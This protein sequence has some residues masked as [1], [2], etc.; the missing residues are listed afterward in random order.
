[1][2]PAVRNK[3]LK[4]LPDLI[5]LGPLAGMAFLVVLVYVSLRTG[6]GMPS[7][8]A[9][10]IFAAISAAGYLV[11]NRRSLTGMLSAKT[12]IMLAV[13]YVL[14]YLLFLSPLLIDGHAGVTGYDVAND[15]VMHA[16]I[17]ESLGDKGLS[18][19]GASKNSYNQIVEVLVIKYGYPVGYHGILGLVYKI[20]GGRAYEYFSAVVACVA[21]GLFFAAFFLLRLFG[22]R[23]IIAIPGALLA[24]TAYL[25][26]GYLMH[27]FAPQVVSTPFVYL[28]MIMLYIS[29]R[30]QPNLNLSILTGVAFAAAFT[31]YS[32]V[33]LVWMGCY[34][35]ILASVLLW[36]SR[37]S[38][39]I[40]KTN[41]RALLLSGAACLMI[42]IPAAG[43]AVKYFG[44]L[45][46]A[47]GEGQLGHLADKS[48][49]M[50]T[51]LGV[52]LG[53]DYRFGLPAG[54][55]GTANL[56]A[57]VVGMI[58]LLVGL[59]R[60]T[61]A[62]PIFLRSIMISWIVPVA[63]LAA[64]GKFYAHGKI[65]QMGAVIFC[66]AIIVGMN[67]AVS[68]ARNGDK[69]LKLSIPVLT[70]VALILIA[71]YISGMFLSSYKTVRGASVSPADKFASLDSINERLKGKGPTLFFEQEDWGAYFL[72]DSN[73]SSPLDQGYPGLTVRL[74]EGHTRWTSNDLNSLEYNDII[75]FN[76][77][78]LS[79]ETDTILMPPNYERVLSDGFY[80]VYKLVE[81]FGRRVYAR[82]SMGNET[83]GPSRVV[84]RPGGSRE[85]SEEVGQAPA[86]ILLSLKYDRAVTS[87]T[88]DWVKAG[89]SWFVWPANPDYA[90]N[91]G[92]AGAELSGNL[93]LPRAGDYR[94]RVTGI[95]ENGLQVKVDGKVLGTLQQPGELLDDLDFGRSYYEAGEHRVDLV[96]IGTGA[97]NYIGDVSF[98][99]DT[100]ISDPVTIIAGNRETK[101]D[102]ST[103]PS[104]LQIKMDGSE[105]WPLGRIDFTLRNE[106]DLPL[107]F[108]WIELLKTPYSASLLDKKNA[109]AGAAQ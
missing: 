6:L 89:S 103:R 28:F 46:G 49:S 67:A 104:A 30:K 96:N 15:S 25:N 84:I 80:V 62:R 108:E 41:A 24:A 100:D 9:L 102:V 97:V 18:A 54:L 55:R 60:M 50:L 74:K 32:I 37:K 2:L 75:G 87:E 12:M 65:L 73:A 101:V 47:V 94:V 90:V 19:S 8:V 88:E 27:G 61:A 10:W 78:V 70:S 56:L 34:A 44:V 48:I 39:E 36:S 29:I 91:M 83:N 63:A 5:T 40:C 76:Y 26:I 7:I 45:M 35:V 93:T 58:F 92:E 95:P 31:V 69:R 17:G 23:R 109:A 22:L 51:L 52:W 38:R 68:W 72:R 85:V 82:F 53:Q 81:P 1:M 4:D 20:L 107:I 105:I 98:E 77:L 42:S 71:A 43:P 3:N 66:V 11:A 64:T 57:L 86:A 79:R 13:C 59:R 21:A 16:V 106:G 14:A 33:T 99:L